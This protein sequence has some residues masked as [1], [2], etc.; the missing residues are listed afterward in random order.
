M[1]AETASP[2]PTE[3]IKQIPCVARRRRYLPGLS[4]FLGYY[5]AYLALV[6][7][8]VVLP[9]WPVKA[10]CVAAASLAIA[11]LYVLGHDAG[12]GSLVPGYRLN[13]W[14]A[15]LAFLPAYAPLA[16]W[17]R[18]HVFLHHNFLRVRGKDMVWMPW[19]LDDYQAASIWRR[20]W[21]RF[22]RTLPGLSFYWTVG[23]WFPYLLFPPGAALGPRLKQFHLDRILVL[24]F[25][26]VLFAALSLLAQAAQA[27]PWAEPVGP[28]GVL[29]LGLVA[30]YLCWT[31]LVGLIDL[32]HHT[33]PRSICFADSSEWDYYD[34]TVKSTVHVILPFGLHWLA[35]NILEHNAHHV[36]PR[37][38]L[39]NLSE[40]QGCLQ[41]AYPED[42]HVEHL[43]LGY[44]LWLFRTCRLYDYERR[45]WLDYDGTPTSESMRPAAFGVA[46]PS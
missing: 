27:W 10:F 37:V 23:N 28:A 39:H 21:Y 43:T 18:A 17:H 35:N 19:S 20:G 14:L 11:G 46:G 4:K 5:A 1:S 40:A 15:R 38:P 13:R 24:G 12:H 30:P 34:A 45:R 36:D 44:T 32:V 22:L 2:S 29:L 7:G 9:G 41:A 25:A 33:H 3:T 6:A 42:I 31:W 16:S 8:A 26:G